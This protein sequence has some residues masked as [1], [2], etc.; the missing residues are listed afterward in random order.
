MKYKFWYQL[1]IKSLGGYGGLRKA[2]PSWAKL[3]GSSHHPNLKEKAIPMSY[4]IAYSDTTKVRASSSFFLTSY[5]D[6]LMVRWNYRRGWGCLKFSFVFLFRIPRKDFNVSLFLHTS[7]DLLPHNSEFPKGN[8]LW[9]LILLCS[10]RLVVNL[11][12][13]NRPH[14]TGN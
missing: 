9:K 11:Y 6:V 8:K 5:W 10:E 4:K 13:K 1:A 14:H 2:A 7:K 12:M 3:K